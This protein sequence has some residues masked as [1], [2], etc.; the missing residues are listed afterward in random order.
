MHIELIIRDADHGHPLPCRL[1]FRGQGVPAM[2]GRD[3]IGQDRAYRGSP[4]L[5]CDGHWQGEMPDVPLSVVV[6]R[7]YEYET[8]V[9]ELAPGDDPGHHHCVEV[10]L[11]RTCNLPAEGWHGGDAHQHVAHGEA[12]LK[13]N[14]PM[15]AA[16]SRAEGV[17]WMVFDSDFTSVPGEPTP[18][19]QELDRQCTAASIHGFTALWAEEY[20]K[21]DLGHLAAFPQDTGRAFADLAGEGVYRIGEGDRTPF[22]TFESARVLQRHGSLAIYSHPS[23]ELGGTP[24]R[25]GNIARELPLDILAAPWAIE[26][27]DLMT[28]EI[29]DPI[30][31]DMWYMWLNQGHRIALCAFN[32]ACFDRAGDR[33]REP[34]AYRR[35]YVKIDRPLAAASLVDGIRAGRTMGTTGPLLLV[36]VDGRDPG[37]VFCADGAVRTLHIR[38]WGGPAYDDPAQVGRIRRVEVIRNG[39]THR[40]WEF[41]GCGQ[42]HVEL[43]LKI[44]ESGLA[45]YVVR[46]H[47]SLP[48]QLAVTSPVYFAAEGDCPPQPHV[49]Q[50]RASIVDGEGSR[51]LS[52]HMELVE[53]ASDRVDVVETRSFGDGLFAGGVPAD[54]RLRARVD[55][56][57]EQVLSPIL[58]N[59]RIYRDLL[60]G[61]RSTDLADPAYYQ[62][63]RQALDH[64]QLEFRLVRRR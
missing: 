35:T 42:D 45:W 16:V 49:A 14:L 13:V 40:A 4:R 61:I 55:G 30:C 26:A 57:D 54:L 23:R 20:P 50:V 59:E 6:S 44:E 31:W 27:V 34:V 10:H 28:D 41:P 60:G 36:D 18:S 17:D 52:G 58:D 12:I 38:A 51:P 15:A 29:D 1:A 53:F 25:V 3:A 2:W 32:D 39:Q 11:R 62:R 48:Q 33:W 64:V 8:R 22:T 21:H 46:V 56:Y 5:W 7:P 9:L 24:G 19:P 43:D 47:G 63:L 37:H